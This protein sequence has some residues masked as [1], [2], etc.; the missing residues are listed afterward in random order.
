[1]AIDKLNT[2]PVQSGYPL[3]GEKVEVYNKHES[4]QILAAH[5]TDTNLHVSLTE[6]TNWND[7]IADGVIHVLATEKL[8]W[9]DHVA[10]TNIHVTSLQKTAW[11]DH[12]V[13]VDIHVLATQKLQWNTAYTHSQDGTIHLTSV[14]KAQLL[15]M[16]TDFTAHI[17]NTIVHI[18]ALERT[19]W[20]NV[21]SDFGTHNLDNTRHITSVERIRWEDAATLISSH[22]LNTI[23]HITASERTDWNNNIDNLQTH[24]T[25][26]NIHVTQAQKNAWDQIAVDLTNHSSDAVRHI[27]AVERAA[28]NDC[29]TDLSDAIV[30]FDGRI[31]S[32]NVRINNVITDLTNLTARVTADEAALLAHRNDKANP[33]ET[34]LGQAAAATS[35]SVWLPTNVK[36]FEE[37]V[38]D[39]NKKL[40]TYAEGMQI[41]QDIAQGIGG[42]KGQVRF[43]IDSITNATALAAMSTVAVVNDIAHAFDTGVF[44]RWNGTNWIVITAAE[45]VPSWN[46]GD[47]IDILQYYGIWQS[48][49]YLGSVTGRSTC[50]L[51][52]LPPA[53]DH[54][55]HIDAIADGSVTDL[56][57]GGRTLLNQ[58]G[59]GTLVATNEKTLTAW[60]QGIRNNLR[61]LFEENTAKVINDSTI[62]L[63]LRDTLSL[64][65]QDSFFTLNQAGNKTLE[66][67]LDAVAFTGS[68]NDLK[69]RPSIPAAPSNATISIVPRTGATSVSFTLNQTTAANLNLGLALVAVSGSYN[70]LA[71]KP[72]MPVVNNVQIGIRANSGSTLYTFTLNQASAQ[73]IDLGLHTVA[74]SGSYNDLADKPTIPSPTDMSGKVDKSTINTGDKLYARIEGVETA[75][76]IEARVFKSI[77]EVF[78]SSG[79]LVIDFNNGTFQHFWANGST[80]STINISFIG[81]GPKSMRRGI[82]THLLLT[83]SSLAP[84]DITINLPAQGATF[85]D[86]DKTVEVTHFIPGNTITIKKAIPSVE[87]S[88]LE[89]SIL[90][91]NDTQIYIRKV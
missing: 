3:P 6:K 45:V 48:T 80:P 12:L 87:E 66:L 59:S 55:I 60:L 63:R 40:I 51:D 54:I 64:H 74:V 73:N 35:G 89:L 8:A 20:N 31:I 36:I 58:P 88:I 43:G 52:S 65:L 30:A 91:M 53:F 82:V 13:D 38:L 24:V 85:V 27:T 84:G 75:L 11:D 1:M 44:H 68:W 70:D 23:I 4:D 14:E 17:A 32:T 5:A 18:T 19:A 86:V 76:D 77:S 62:T 47:F 28:W 16:L 21:V 9:N 69:D 67:V 56:K 71:D 39:L 34:N 79:N 78:P 57:I 46:V 25:N 83:A 2:N 49:N 10:N 26:S 50:R 90:R 7:H 41:A 72:T 29:I 42:Y 37:N 33:H 15:A 81:S 61:Y 22:A